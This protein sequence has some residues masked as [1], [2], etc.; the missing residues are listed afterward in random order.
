ME[1]TIVQLLRE[2]IDKVDSKVDRIDEKVNQL[3]AFKYQIIGGSVLISA[4]VGIVLQILIAFMS[5]Q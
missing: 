2:A 3:L 5:K 1:S 4:I